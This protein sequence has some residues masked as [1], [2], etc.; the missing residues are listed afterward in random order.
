MGTCDHTSKFVCHL[1]GVRQELAEGIEGL[2]GVHWKLAEGIRSL[3]GVRQERAEGDQALARMASRVRRKKT[4]R[5]TGRSL[6]VIEKLA[7]SHEGLVG[8][9]GHIDF[10]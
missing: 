6:R 3:L 1:P 9:D 10:N 2:P 4:K 7:G 8:L 5:L